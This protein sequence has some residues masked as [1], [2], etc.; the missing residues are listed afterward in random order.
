MCVWNRQHMLHAKFQYVDNNLIFD[1]EKAC[2]A[3]T[4]LTM[5]CNCRKQNTKLFMMWNCMHNGILVYPVGFNPQYWNLKL[6]IR[7]IGTH[8][9]MWSRWKCVLSAKSNAQCKNFTSTWNVY[10]ITDSS[11]NFMYRILKGHTTMSQN[12]LRKQTVTFVVNK[13]FNTNLLSVSHISIHILCEI[14]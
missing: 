2:C 11:T 4:I 13:R 8:G 1:M 3:Q 5:H 9:N 12:S 6:D 14:R 10:T 7:K